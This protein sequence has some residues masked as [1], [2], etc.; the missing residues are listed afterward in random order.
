MCAE[1][2]IA[3]GVATLGSLITA[4]YRFTLPAHLPDGTPDPTASVVAEG[5]S[6]APAAAAASPDLADQLLHAAGAAF[7]DGYNL[8]GVVGGLALV[9]TAVLTRRRL[10]SSTEAVRVS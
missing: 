2:G 3:L 10:D 9:G 7:T 4:A 8:V 5:I 1:L 6:A